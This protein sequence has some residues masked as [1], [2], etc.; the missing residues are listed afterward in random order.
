MSSKLGLLLSLTFMMAVLLLSGDLINVAILKNTLHS[1]SVVVSYRLQ[2]DCRITVE[3][4]NL[5]QSYGATYTLETEGRTAF[6]IGETV[7]YFLSK[8]YAPFV[9]QKQRMHVTVRRSAVIGYYTN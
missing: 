1:L 8:E 6:R 9:L 5:I 3:T 7:T 4:E 2:T